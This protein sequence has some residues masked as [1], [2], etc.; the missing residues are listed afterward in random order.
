MQLKQMHRH[1]TLVQLAHYFGLHDNLNVE[2]QRAFIG[3]LVQ[4]HKAG[5][6][7]GEFEVTVP[8]CVW[9][10]KVCSHGFLKTHPTLR[11][12]EH[13]NNVVQN[14]STLY[15]CAEYPSIAYYTSGVLHRLSCGDTCIQAQVS[16]PD[17]Q[18]F[19]TGVTIFSQGRLCCSKVKFHSRWCLMWVLLSRVPKSYK[20][21]IPMMLQRPAINGKALLL[22]SF[23]ANIPQDICNFDCTVRSIEAKTNKRAMNCCP[24]LPY[25]G[26]CLS[27]CIF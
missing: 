23:S 4:R 1:L 9:C 7:F 20:T 17:Q 24:C 8:P 27:G 13:N 6:Q 18:P 25:G 16:L 3:E 19:I 22:L 2:E 5:L 15:T 12:I 21:Y 26:V 11:N 10:G 14:T